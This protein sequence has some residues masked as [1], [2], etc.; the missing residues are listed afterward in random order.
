MIDHLCR[1]R[2]IRSQLSYRSDDRWLNQVLDSEMESGL[3][4]A[5]K[6]I[7]EWLYEH[8]DNL[9]EDILADVNIV[10]VEIK[11]HLQKYHSELAKGIEAVDQW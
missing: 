11:S 2:A 9:K 5:K 8:E 6:G 7:K 3:T 10:L 4:A 1:I